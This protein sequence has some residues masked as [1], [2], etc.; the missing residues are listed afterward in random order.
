VWWRQKRGCLG[1]AQGVVWRGSWTCVR[2]LHAARAAA[3]GHS[4]CGPG[5]C[6]PACSPSAGL[7]PGPYCAGCED[8]A[9]DNVNSNS[10]RLSANTHPQP[11]VMRCAQSCATSGRAGGWCCQPGCAGARQQPCRGVACARA[12]P[13]ASTGSW[14][15]SSAAWHPPSHALRGPTLASHPIATLAHRCL[16]RLPTPPRHSAGAHG[17]RPG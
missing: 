13:T 11:L 12:A 7:A 14:R 9:R 15:S 3:S 1:G 8:R 6:L 16:G 2:A 17:A 5:N 10:G 4:M